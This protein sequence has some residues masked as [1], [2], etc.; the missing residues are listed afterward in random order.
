MQDFPVH[1]RHRN[2][3]ASPEAAQLRACRARCR[4]VLW[5]R[6]L[7]VAALSVVLSVASPARAAFPGRD[8]LLAIQPLH[9]KGIVLVWPNGRDQRRICTQAPACGHPGRPRFSPD[10]RSVL[11]AAPAIRLVGT[12][13]SCQNCQFGLASSPAFLPSGTLISFVSNGTLYEDG[14]DGIRR[15]TVEGAVPLSDAV[16]SASGRL[17]AVSDGNVLA[18]K[19]GKL[20]S[21][22]RGGSPSWSPDGSHLAIVRNGW[23]TVVRPGG[24]V[25]TRLVRGTAPAFSPDGRWIAFVGNRHRV[26]VVRASGGVPRAVGHVRGLALD[27]QPLPERASRCVSPPGAHVL[28]RSGQVVVTAETGPRGGAGG[29]PDTAAMGCLYANGRERL[30]ELNTFN[31][32]N[33]TTSIGP[34]AVSAP[35]AALVSTNSDYHYGGR[36]DSTAVFDLRTGARSGFAGSSSCPG[37]GFGSVPCSGIDGVVVGSDGVSAVHLNGGP[38]GPAAADSLRVLCA[39]ESLCLASNPFGV[40]VSS[41]SPSQGP[42]NPA[43]GASLSAGGAGGGSCPSVSLCVLAAGTLYVSTD[44]TGGSGSW[45]RTDLPGS[46]DFLAVDCPTTSLCLATTAHGQ[47]AVSTDPTG[48]PSAW[49]M[50]AVDPG[51]YMYGISCPSSSECVATDLNGRVL[52]TTDPTGGPGAWTARQVTPTGLANVTCPSASLCVALNVLS[53]VVVSTEPTSGSWTSVAAPNPKDLS[54]PSASF[55]A[56]LS[57][58]ATIR[59]STDP[60]SGSWTSYTLSGVGVLQSLSCTSAS[61]CVAAGQGNGDVYVTTSPTSGPSS[62]KPVLA[63]K[64]DCGI[65]SSACGTERIIASDRTGV[66]TLDSSTEF[67]AQTGPQL[68]GLALTGDTLSWTDHGSPRSMEL[69]P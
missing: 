33:T 13:G 52:T 66:H 10:G 26:F 4:S 47:V 31:S 46:L 41:T 49:T 6:F 56:A 14:I 23:I 68:T 53:G 69:R 2:R 43:A 16:W 19:P 5:R 29:L 18:G 44:P 67:E 12:D 50:S 64:I 30:L 25:V 28:A 62:W 45:T 61:F 57:G 32:E 58:P 34:A 63:D 20:R 9:G 38:V 48:G 60:A 51:H 42:W 65:E 7:P 37:Y 17:A 11:F 40:I 59:I 22:G 24:G 8:G 55:C 54:C 1:D 21:V 3:V 15:A 27:W 35:Y 39:S 36:S